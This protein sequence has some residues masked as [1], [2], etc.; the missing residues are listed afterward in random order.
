MTRLVAFAL[1]GTALVSWQR[2]VGQASFHVSNGRN[3]SERLQAPVFDW[4]G[5]LLAGSYWRAE[6][7]GGATA[8]SLSP[9]LEY[10]SEPPFATGN[11][12][13]VKFWEPG[14]FE[15]SSVN[16]TG[17]FF[18]VPD[19][20]PN[21]WAW[22]QV[23]VWDLRLGATYEEALSRGVGGYGES[24]LFYAQGGNP[25]GVVPGLPQPLLGLQSFSVLQEVPEP[26][27]VGLTFFGC[28][29]FLWIGLKPSGVA[30]PRFE[31]T[32]A[33][34]SVSIGRGDRTVASVPHPQR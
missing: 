33:G 30:N 26:S 15:Q 2:L 12:G 13:V 29:A 27:V 11:R 4:D 3:T 1:A 6:V 21:G 8:T 25:L 20:A 23:K 28:I 31:A 14:Y 34:L 16:T 19:V 7:Y 24:A 9:L 22:L 32:A 10:H 17:G 18:S 5:S